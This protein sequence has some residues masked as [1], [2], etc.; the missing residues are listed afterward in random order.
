MKDTIT[1]EVS[2]YSLHHLEFVFSEI[3]YQKR[4]YLYKET[5]VDSASSLAKTFTAAVLSDIYIIPFHSLCSMSGVT[6]V[7]ITALAMR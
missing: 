1:G 6:H 4:R 7:N 5:N 2:A 3:E